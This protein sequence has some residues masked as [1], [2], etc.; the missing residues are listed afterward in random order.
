MGKARR[1]YI[2]AG[3]RVEKAREEARREE[4]KREEARRKRE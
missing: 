2:A 1:A 4:A 3:L